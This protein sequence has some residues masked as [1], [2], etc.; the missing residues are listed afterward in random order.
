M[1]RN[2]LIAGAGI[3]GLAAALALHDKGFGVEVLESARE[4][5]PLGVGLN[6]QPAA[7]A[8]LDK[9]GLGESLAASGIPTAEHVYFDHLGE[10]LFTEPRGLAAG[11]EWP[12]YSVHRGELQSLLLE[13]VRERIGPRAV[14][15]GAQLVDVSQDGE[16]V[17]AT[18][19][20][21]ARGEHVRHTGRVLIGADGAHSVVRELLYPGSAPLRW[22]GAHFWRGITEV[23]SFGTG[24]SFHHISD[25]RGTRVVAYPISAKAAE[26]GRVLV[27]WV[28]EAAVAEPGTPLERSWN[29]AGRL[30]DLLA[31]LEGWELDPLGLRE[32][33]IGGGPILEYPMVDRD[34]LPGW[35]AGRV[36]LLGDAA[37]LMYPVGANGASQ[38]ILDARALAEALDG[39]GLVTGLREY[40]RL[41]LART[42]A[43]VLANR[44]MHAAEKASAGRAD[45]GERLAAITADYRRATATGAAG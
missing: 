27:N 20:D 31:H 25:A 37:H 36:S 13:Q 24:R 19:F 23:D 4:V 17:R 43:V 18:V 8:A 12:Q 11:H 35:G 39:S 3:G 44:E 9:L 10:R 5:R 29:R 15:T 7:V 21:R 45:R 32:L 28:V 30:P 34:P 41:R 38:A 14:R 2:I 6:I 16:S 22:N 26:S 40:E 1:T 42:T 33:F